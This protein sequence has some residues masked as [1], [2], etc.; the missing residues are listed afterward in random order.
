M[1]TPTFE[2][3]TLT[4]THITNETAEAQRGRDHFQKVV[5]GIERVMNAECSQPFWGTAKGRGPG[6]VGGMTWQ[7]WAVF[8]GREV[9]R[10]PEGHDRV[11]PEHHYPPKHQVT[12]AGTP[13]PSQAFQQ[14]PHQ[15]SPPG[16][17]PDPVRHEGAAWP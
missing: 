11:R 3:C 8:T 5:G 9:F 10:K 16:L 17:A 2:R 1:F 4:I 12:W 15:G 13:G 7:G 14:P 6:A